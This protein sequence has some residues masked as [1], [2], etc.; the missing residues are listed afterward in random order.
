MRLFEDEIADLLG[1]NGIGF[2]AE[3]FPAYTMLSATKTAYGSVPAGTVRIILIPLKAFSIE[4]AIEQSMAA[5]TLSGYPDT[6]S[7]AEDRWMKN[8]EMMV[9]RLLAHLGIFRSIYARDCEIKKISRT[10]AD[11]F[12]E[13]T[14][15]YGGA[16]CRYCYGIFLKREREKDFGLHNADGRLLSGTLIAVAEFSNA[17]RWI[18]DGRSVRSYEWIRYASLP[19]VRING[20]M[21]KILNRFIGDI[22][23]DDIMSYADLE[24]SDG[25]AYRRLGFSADGEKSPVTFAVVPGSW[26]R[27]PVN[28]PKQEH[29]PSGSDTA[30]N[31]QEAS[32]IRYFRN[33]GS[34][35]YRLRLY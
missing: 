16:K 33:F 10:E 25:Q 8:R 26:Q 34:L 3:T 35:K 31:G 5:G 4:E 21:G 28:S 11:S 14:H 18:K 19:D 6:I 15:S 30:A 20:G 29:I 32:S 22:G 17:R 7:I 23:P 2:T 1:R 24:W 9:G 12:L 27:I 13:R